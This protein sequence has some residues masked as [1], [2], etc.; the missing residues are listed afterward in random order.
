MAATAA[1]LLSGCAA[2]STRP[3]PP[4]PSPTSVNANQQHSAP[5]CPPARGPAASWPTGF[6][7]DFP[8]LPSLSLGTVENNPSGIKIA[9]W[10]SPVDLR[11]AVLFAVQALP[12][13][14]FVIGRGDAELYEADI[15]FARA[16]VRGLLR[17]DAASECSVYGFLAV[18]QISP[19]GPVTLLP[20]HHGT[21]P[22]PLPFATSPG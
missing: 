17:I 12:K 3:P 8:T 13:A 9:E 15:P 2:G 4:A 20:P 11:S 1:A 16:N 18:E 6:P 14:G 10:S 7:K 19:G 22:S 21:S 5:A